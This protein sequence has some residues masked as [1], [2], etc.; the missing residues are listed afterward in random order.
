MIFV[1]EGKGVLKTMYGELPFGYGDYLV[2]PR[3]TIYQI[4]FNDAITGFLS[5]NHSVPIRFPKK[6]LSKYGQLHGAF[7]LL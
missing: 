5:L 3:G 4:E 1:H 6:Y 7:A 2:I